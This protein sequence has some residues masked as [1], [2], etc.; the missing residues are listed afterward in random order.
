MSTKKPASL[1]AMFPGFMAKGSAQPSPVVKPESPEPAVASSATE[2]PA[3]TVE[4]APGPAP[5]AAPKPAV[6]GRS[7]QGRAAPSPTPSRPMPK[8]LGGALISTT[9][10]LD[11]GRYKDIK[12]AGVMSG[13]TFQDIAV[14]AI[15]L[16][17]AKNGNQG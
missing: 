10:K 13:K 6:P 2:P 11:H 12:L 1:T 3:V 15:D 7:K 14:E 4:S 8:E 5:A 9:V 17:L 16:W